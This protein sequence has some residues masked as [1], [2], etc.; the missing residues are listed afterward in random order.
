MMLI[1]VGMAYFSPR[2][3]AIGLVIIIALFTFI[4]AGFRGRLVRVVTSVTLTLAVVAF[5]VLLYEFF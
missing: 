3:L 5:L 2:H 4:E 1:I